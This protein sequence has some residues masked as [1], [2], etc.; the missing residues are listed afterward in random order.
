MNKDLRECISE[1]NI[2]KFKIIS[3]E[4]SKSDLN[5]ILCYLVNKNHYA[6]VD[7]LSKLG[8]DFSLM[9]GRCLFLAIHNGHIEMIRVL[10]KNKCCDVNM[11]NGLPLLKAVEVGNLNAIKEFDKFNLNYKLDHGKAFLKACI[12]NNLNIVEFLLNKYPAYSL[13]KDSSG[14]QYAILNNNEAMLN[15]LLENG[16]IMNDKHLSSARYIGNNRIINIVEARL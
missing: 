12:L 10:L 15:L 7:A 13:I 4:W 11:R 1:Y 5:R 9:N 3:K 14:A 16:A 8:Y 2:N 6:F